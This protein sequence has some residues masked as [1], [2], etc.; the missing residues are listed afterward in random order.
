VW[1]GGHCFSEQTVSIRLQSI[2]LSVQSF[3][4]QLFRGFA[5]GRSGFGAN[6]PDEHEEMD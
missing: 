5:V 6:N 4:H 3:R 2:D 1:V